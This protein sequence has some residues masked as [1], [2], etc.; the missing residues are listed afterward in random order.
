MHSSLYILAYH[1]RIWPI[2]QQFGLSL[3]DFGL[4][5]KILANHSRIWPITLQCVLSLNN[6][7]YHSKI[8]PITLQFVLSLSLINLAYHSTIW[9]ITLQFGLSLN[10]NFY[11]ISLYNL[12]CIVLSLNAMHQQLLC[13]YH[14]HNHQFIHLLY[15][16]CIFPHPSRFSPSLS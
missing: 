2:T 7:F 8:W 6:L 3:N 4:S 5:L 11:G 16:G 10:N 13:I 1:S 14:S 9:P 12:A 15:K